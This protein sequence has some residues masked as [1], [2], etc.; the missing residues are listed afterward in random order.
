[1][2]HV[3]VNPSSKSGLARK[4]WKHLKA[5][6]DHAK[7]TYIVHFT[8]SEKDLRNYT[9]SITDR[10]LFE[11]NGSLN[12]LIVL[13]GD[14]TLNCVVN[15]I[16]DMAHTVVSYLPTGTSNDCA[17][18]LGISADPMDTVAGLKKCGV[19]R[20][21]D[22]GVAAYGRKKRR[23][24]V[25]CGFGFDAATC[26]AVMQ[27]PFKNLFNK[28]GLGKLIYC[29]VALK[30]LISLETVSCDLYLDDKPPIH[31]NRLIFASFM[32][33]PYEGGGFMLCPDADSTD[34]MLDV[35][36]ASNLT[37]LQALPIFPLALKGKHKGHRGIH[38]YRAKKIRIIASKKLCIHTDGEICGYYT[39]LSLGTEDTKL[40]Y[41]KA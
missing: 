32:Q 11:H 41:R 14:G 35:C 24:N 1:M 8:K 3:I 36:V 34:G 4:Q 7:I 39:E 27:S 38:M 9:K 12:R 13:G 17:R 29:A 33:L 25:S 30:Q 10:Q 31:F 6:L 26:D 40:N 16:D 22:V 37:A 2:Y 23:F 21:T 5:A 28:L 20:Q 18:A 15:A 19:T